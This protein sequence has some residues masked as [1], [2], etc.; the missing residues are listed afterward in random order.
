[1]FQFSIESD[2]ADAN[3]SVPEITIGVSQ[4]YLNKANW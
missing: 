2:I 1:M 3:I 4:W